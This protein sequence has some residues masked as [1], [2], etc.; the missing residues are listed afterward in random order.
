MDAVY[1]SADH[2]WLLLA[3]LADFA[4]RDRKRKLKAVKISG[5]EWRPSPELG[6]F[7]ARFARG[8][9]GSHGGHPQAPRHRNSFDNSDSNNRPHGPGGE[10]TRPPPANP[11][12]SQHGIPSPQVNG[13]PMYGMVPPLGPIRLGTAFANSAEH[14]DKSSNEDAEDDQGM[15]YKDA[16]REW[17]NIRT[18][19]ETYAEALG[20]DYLPLPP[21]T[22]TPISTPFGP[23]LQYRT[24]TIA[25]VWG[26]YYAARIMLYR[27]H[28][29][30]PPA[31][32]VAAGVATPATDEYAQMIGR[33]AGGIYYPQRY[34]FRA[35]RL[36]PNLGSA[37][38]ELTVPTYFAAVQYTDFKQ[39]T[40]VVTQMHEVARL[41]G[42]E[43]A[44]VMIRGC[45]SAWI[46]AAK[47]GRGPPYERIYNHDQVRTSLYFYDNLA[48]LLQGTPFDTLNNRDRDNPQQEDNSERRFVAISK[49]SRNHWAMGILSLEDDILNLDI[50]DRR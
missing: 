3:R 8:G 34:N 35:G 13:R 50:E 22:T 19:F 16:E 46:V 45:E 6:K 21:D 30:M 49:S 29:S 23:A 11:K 33:I 44:N 12:S 4:Y 1:G 7:M 37:L 42:W 41:T 27:F 9:P 31:M 2:L 40:W 5:A 32:M 48:N 10:K 17:E 24:H 14:N 43:S 25:V 36:N 15:T 38:V 18:A 47:Q 28:P 20:R 39:R 26:F